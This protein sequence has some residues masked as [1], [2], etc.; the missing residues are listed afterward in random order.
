M[1][2]Y[3]LDITHT[4][5]FI[6]LHSFH[7][8]A[9]NG[10]LTTNTK[11]IHIPFESFGGYWVKLEGFRV[12]SKLGFAIRGFSWVFEG[13]CEPCLHYNFVVKPGG[14]GIMSRKRTYK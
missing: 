2:V 5:T 14:Y 12:P 6:Y 3:H 13:L 10:T 9:H 7:V 1:D 11:K 4:Q 8:H